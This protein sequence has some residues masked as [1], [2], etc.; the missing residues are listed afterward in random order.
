[1]PSL[2]LYSYDV[3]FAFGGSST[4]FAFN[5]K[6]SGWVAMLANKYSR[7]IDVINRG[8]AG[9]NSRWAKSIFFNSFPKTVKNE[10]EIPLC[11]PD[12]SSIKQSMPD[13]ES[14]AHNLILKTMGPNRPAKVKLVTIFLGV[15]DA[16]MEG[17][18]A[19]VPLAEFHQNL[20]SMIDHLADP[21]SE[22]YSPEIK[23]ILITPPPLSEPMWARTV[24]KQNAPMDRSEEN[25]KLYAEEVIKVGKKRNI[26]VV[27]V[28][29]RIKNEINEIQAK[30][31]EINALTNGTTCT[32]SRMVEDNLRWF[33]YDQFFYDGLHFNANGNTILF[34]MLYETIITNYPDLVPWKLPKFVPSVAEVMSLEKKL[35]AVKSIRSRL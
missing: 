14:S 8:F 16:A 32:G 26:P 15:N 2:G 28:F 35:K 24:K 18:P 17:Y 30:Q 10:S 6:T 7:R 20:L 22:Y 13:T 19:H 34:E 1:M 9:F 21:N 23:F 31:A 27:D 11:K 5:T 3:F 29:T 25:A 4:E 33:G 12:T